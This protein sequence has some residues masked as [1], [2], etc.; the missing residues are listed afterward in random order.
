MA[1]MSA[2]KQRKDGEA[3]FTARV[4]PKSESTGI[5]V[6]GDGRISCSYNKYELLQGISI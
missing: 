1:A 6:Y 2:K 3:V 4:F 5:A